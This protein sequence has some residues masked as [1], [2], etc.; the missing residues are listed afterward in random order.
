MRWYVYV[1]LCVGIDPKKLRNK[2]TT[3]P[4]LCPYFLLTCLFIFVILSLLML[5]TSQIII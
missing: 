2:A 5:D 4:I 1:Y 3:L